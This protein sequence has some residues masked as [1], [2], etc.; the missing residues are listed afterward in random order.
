MVKL[1]HSEAV[2]GLLKNYRA[3]DVNLGSGAFSN[4]F[5]FES[6]DDLNVKYAVKIM[7]KEDLNLEMLH[8]VHEEVQIL[9]MLDHP[10]I[11]NYI[12]SFEDEV[13]LFIITEYL[14]ESQDLQKMIDKQIAKEEGNVGSRNEPLFPEE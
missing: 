3:L 9:A 7:F 6:R 11:V 4:V 1:D 2:K 12:E 10:N 14:E 13:N 8:T 5:L